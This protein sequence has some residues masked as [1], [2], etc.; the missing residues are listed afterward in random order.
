ML[1]FSV[2]SLLMHGQSGSSYF[3][4]TMAC[5]NQDR[6]CTIVGDNAALCGLYEALEITHGADTNRVQRGDCYDEHGQDG[7]TDR[8]MGPGKA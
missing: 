5:R 6:T 2:N 7:E 8:G 3:S 1:V 4:A